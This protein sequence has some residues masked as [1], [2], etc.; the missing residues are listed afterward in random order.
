VNPLPGCT[1]RPPCHWGDIKAGTW[2]TRARAES[3]ADS[4]TVGKSKYVERDWI[5]DTEPGMDKSGRRVGV[6]KMSVLPI[7]I[8]M[9]AAG[10]CIEI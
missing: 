6:K 5:D 9:K 1:A 2:S 10:N 7:T 3:K 8:M 4:F